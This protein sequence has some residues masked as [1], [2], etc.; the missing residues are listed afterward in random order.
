MIANVPI[1]KAMKKFL[2]KQSS[3]IS[4]SGKTQ[5]G[6]AEKA[7]VAGGFG[8]ILAVKNVLDFDQTEEKKKKQKYERKDYVNPIP[9]KQTPPVELIDEK[10]VDRSNVGKLLINEH[11][12]KD[13]RACVL[14]QRS[15]FEFDVND[16]KAIDEKLD[17]L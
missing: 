8:M 3:G 15:E 6:L 9:I 13:H 10:D 17:E 11:T 5:L 14:K 7:A 1:H 4:S 16:S 2:S 12:I